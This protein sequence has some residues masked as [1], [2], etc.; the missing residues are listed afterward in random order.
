MGCGV[1]AVLSHKSRWSW[2][3]LGSASP[4][5]VSVSL[6]LASGLLI[7]SQLDKVINNPAKPAGPGT[8]THARPHTC[9]LACLHICSKSQSDGVRPVKHSQEA[10]IFGAGGC[11]SV[12][13][14]LVLITLMSVTKNSYLVSRRVTMEK[15][16]G[17][18][19]AC[20]PRCFVFFS[21]MLPWDGFWAVCYHIFSFTLL[22]FRSHAV[23][24]GV[25]SMI[26]KRSE[27][28]SRR[29]ISCSSVSYCYQTALTH[30]KA[31]F[32]D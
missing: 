32:E 4:P 25:K 28:T 5:P 27:L 29:K 21:L 18:D 17:K 3:F 20:L 2:C 8:D 13:C 26:F 7:I 31:I 14:Q 16:K 23:I 24:R 10:S 19:E 9:T 11:V 12:L 22:C 1:C 6:C 30:K 15:E